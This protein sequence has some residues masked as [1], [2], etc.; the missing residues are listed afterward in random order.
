MM[1]AETRA[2][3]EHFTC[4]SYSRCA[5]RLGAELSRPP[6]GFPD[7]HFGVYRIQHLDVGDA[8]SGSMVS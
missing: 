4:G 5:D 3:L 2:I 7:P 1:Q 8:L 6:G